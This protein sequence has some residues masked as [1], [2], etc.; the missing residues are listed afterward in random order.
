[1]DT[2]DRLW[3]A[4]PGSPTDPVTM[5]SSN[6]I[7]RDRAQAQGADRDRPVGLPPVPGVVPRARQ[8]KQRRRVTQARCLMHPAWIPIA[9]RP[10]KSRYRSYDWIWWAPAVARLRRIFAGQVRA[11]QGSARS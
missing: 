3:I 6:S 11:G 4:S 7:S 10:G 2:S 1:V 5:A 9:C 8:G